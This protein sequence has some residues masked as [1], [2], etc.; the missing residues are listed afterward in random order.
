MINQTKPNIMG[1][2][3]KLKS[4]QKERTRVR[5]KCKGGPRERKGGRKE[6]DGWI[7]P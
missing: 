4:I 5:K 3:G 6:G 1:P 7:C 2:W